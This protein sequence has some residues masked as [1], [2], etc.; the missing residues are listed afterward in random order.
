[1]TF[2]YTSLLYNRLYFVWHGPI[3]TAEIRS[4]SDGSRI[5]T[6]NRLPADEHLKD[7]LRDRTISSFYPTFVFMLLTPL[8]PYYD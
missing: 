6:G 5:I 3:R 1:M 8:A 2:K 7:R 4:F